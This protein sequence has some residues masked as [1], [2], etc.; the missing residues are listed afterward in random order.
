M[1]KFGTEASEAA[2]MVIDALVSQH[3]AKGFVETVEGTAFTVK[4]SF[5]RQQV[6]YST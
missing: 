3:M 6:K 4:K 2:L 5:N 1:K